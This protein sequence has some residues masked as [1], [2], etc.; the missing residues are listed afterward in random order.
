[1]REGGRI[2]SGS[3]GDVFDE[4]SFILGEFVLGDG[5][6]G[7]EGMF[8]FA[9]RLN[10]AGMVEGS[11]DELTIPCDV[12]E[13]LENR[14]DYQFRNDETTT[15]KIWLTARVRGARSRGISVA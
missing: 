13:K 14:A 9:S 4:L 15:V 8:S 6:G 2:G 1:L 5:S 10:R 7:S 12:L 3:I 11:I